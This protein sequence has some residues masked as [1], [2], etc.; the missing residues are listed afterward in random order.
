LFPGYIFARFDA[1]LMLHKICYTRGVQSVV[2]FNG[3]PLPV[4]DEIIAL[5]QSQVGEDGFVRIG[6]DLRPGDEVMIRDGSLKGIQGIFHQSINDT[7]RVRILLTAINYQASLIIE[8]E[9]VR[10]NDQS[11]SLT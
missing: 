8:K 3:E 6:E 11:V 10:K 1:G 9:V 7:G 4:D 5:I 2:S